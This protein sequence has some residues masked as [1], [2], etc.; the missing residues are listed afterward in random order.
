MVSLILIY[1]INLISLLI[2]ITMTV[3]VPGISRQC[4]LIQ[5]CS[6]NYVL[7]KWDK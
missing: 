3:Q 5:I 6:D 7:K 4:G 1:S 2:K